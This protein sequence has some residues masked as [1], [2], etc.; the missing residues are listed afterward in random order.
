MTEGNADVV[1]AEPEIYGGPVANAPL[2][3]FISSDALVA[4]GVPI[5]LL[6]GVLGQAANA[7][8]PADNGLAQQ[9]HAERQLKATDAATKFPENEARS[10]GQMASVNDMAQQLPQ[11]VSGMAG[12]IAG[13]IGGALK[14]LTEMPQQ[15]AQSAQ[16]FLQQGMG[17]MQSSAE[18]TPDDLADAALA[19]DFGADASE[20]GAGGGGAGGG[21]VGGGGGFGGTTPMSMLGPPAT[22]GASTVPTSSRAM[23]PAAA[24]TPP[25]PTV[26][27]GGMGG[28][29]M[30]P[31]GAM[32]GG[33]AGDG[34][35]DKAATKRVSVPSVKNGAPVQ[36]RVAVPPT[37]PTV[38]KQV[39]GKTIT[40][41][42]IIV[43]SD[44]TVDEEADDKKGR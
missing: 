43:P 12:G 31:P 38:S 10:E 5:E 40:S 22:P 37:G 24:V 7:G 15:L 9:G 11:L 39:E 41:R 13:A 35:D 42:R 23:P 25:T 33:A 14:P 34:K 2:P 16:G 8:D 27:G 3:P 18:A 20:L 32:H 6:L 17:A 30:M 19:S 29:P 1:S 4:G 28:Y 26:Q 44:K 21:S 36:G